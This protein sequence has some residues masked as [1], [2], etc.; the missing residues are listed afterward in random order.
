MSRILKLTIALVIIIGAHYIGILRPVENALIRFTKPVYS[1]LY[2][3]NDTD[4][5]RDPD[6]LF[7]ENAELTHEVEQLKNVLAQYET[8][9]EENEQLHASVT[10]HESTAYTIQT[11][12]VLSR[13]MVT[14]PTR[15]TI[16]AGS[17]Q[18]IAEGNF[19]TDAEGRLIGRV[20]ETLPHVSYVQLLTHPNVS[21]AV[22]ASKATTPM[23]VARGDLSVSLIVELIPQDTVIAPGDVLLTAPVDNAPD[24]IRVGTVTS[25]DEKTNELFKT[26][27]VRPF[28]N[29]DL[30]H[31]VNVFIQAEPVVEKVINNP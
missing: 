8:L 21:F 11:T 3:Q 22:R 6:V 23:G 12:T 9:A 10:F 2:T 7:A 31:V 24:G 28:M 18:G 29:R 20:V 5:S 27:V 1:F 26:A 30:L 4:T 13:N 19:V 25:V 16:A 17:S 14:N 15:I